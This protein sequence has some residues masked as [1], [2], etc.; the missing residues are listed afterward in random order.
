MKI[1]ILFWVSLALLLQAQLCASAGRPNVVLILADDLGYADTGYTGCKDFETPNIDRLAENG[2]V[3]T[4]GYASHPFCAPTRAGILTGRNQHRFGFQE[5]PGPKF[6][7]FGLPETEITLPELL[8]KAGYQNA[9]VGKWHLGVEE[10]HH[11]LNRGFQEFFGFFPG[12]H[13]YHSSD[14]AE[15][16]IHSWTHPLEH[17]GKSV[18]VEGYLTDQLT[19]S[20]VEFIKSEKDSPFF[21]FM[22][23][24]APHTPLQASEEY[25]NRVGDIEDSTLRIY[26]A[27]IVAMDDGIGKIMATLEQEGLLENTL[28]FFMSDNGGSPAAPSNNLPFR[29]VKGTALEGGIHVPYLVYWKGKL[30]PGTYDKPVVSYDV[31]STALA[32]AGADMPDDRVIDSK[33]L[34]PYLSG[35]NKEAP[36]KHLFWQLADLQWAIRSESDKAINVAGESTYLFD[37]F[38][39]LG[40][41]E[42]LSST[43]PQTVRSLEETFHQWRQDLPEP[44]HKSDGIADTPGVA[45]RTQQKA[46]NDLRQTRK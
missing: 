41:S 34:L 42:D 43:K 7:G 44:T 3:C 12:G 15:T 17:N 32:I 6:S 45:S 11:P 19:D 16:D 21:L 9:L 5:N 20:A 4:N 35:E 18:A 40:E 13:D 28:V 2:I 27:M 23:Y 33:N 30:A 37:M 8:S 25:L 38:T 22:S 24:N 29:G 46:L 31:F 10:K 36:H 39:D 26:A 14:P 1:R